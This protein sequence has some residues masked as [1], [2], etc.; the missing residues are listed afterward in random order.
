MSIDKHKLF[1]K[2]QM[3]KTTLDIYRNYLRLKRI[4]IRLLKRL[5]ERKSKGIPLDSSMENIIKLV[6]NVLSKQ[7]NTLPLDIDASENKNNDVELVKLASDIVPKYQESTMNAITTQNNDTDN[8]LIKLALE[9]LSKNQ[10][11]VMDIVTPQTN[12]ELV[13]LA[14]DTIKPHENDT[15]NELVKLAMDILSKEK[16]SIIDT[17]MPQ[18]DNELIKLA[19]NILSKDQTATTETN[20]ENSKLLELALNVVKMANSEK[21]F[22]QEFM[23]F[24]TRINQIGQNDESDNEFTTSFVFTL[25]DH[26]EISEQ[27]YTLID[28]LIMKYSKENESFTA[29]YQAYFGYKE[30]MNIFKESVRN[31]EDTYLEL[32]DVNTQIYI[33]YYDQ[34][35]DEKP[36]DNETEQYDEQTGGGPPSCLSAENKSTILKAIDLYKD[37]YF[38]PNGTLIRGKLNNQYKNDAIVKKWISDYNKESNDKS[39]APSWF[40]QQLSQYTSIPDC[41][42]QPEIKAEPTIEE[43]PKIDEKPKTD[44]KSNL[45]EPEENTDGIVAYCISKVKNSN[46]LPEEFQENAFDQLKVISVTTDG[47]L[48]TKDTNFNSLTFNC[49]F[50]FISTDGKKHNMENKLYIAFLSKGQVCYFGEYREGIEN[51]NTIDKYCST[52]TE[53]KN[54]ANEPRG[55]MKNANV[56]QEPVAPTGPFEPTRP[57]IPAAPVV[58]ATPMQRPITPP[59]KPKK[60]PSYYAYIALNDSQKLIEKALLQDFINNESKKNYANHYREFTKTNKDPAI[61]NALAILMKELE[62]AQ[63]FKERKKVVKYI[64]ETFDL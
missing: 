30:F 18:T 59:Q 60:P 3:L 57:I 41:S 33:N 32:L 7:K 58:P 20:N 43:K 19:L 2:I 51:D 47:E 8:E 64:K 12:N 6:L 17:V 42:I 35:P 13:K 45:P 10:D 54:N 44:E 26:Y 27:E 37:A 29:Y 49:I 15:D 38:K 31:N 25:R 52:T 4:S 39:F 34:F 46:K 50:K 40:D 11:S 5:K 56:P 16:E 9:I 1:D 62:E 55:E 22:A 48:L 23:D 53:S 14:V 28:E 63:I 21:T 61:K 36:P 24:I